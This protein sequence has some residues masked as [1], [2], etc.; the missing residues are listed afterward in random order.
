LSN[1]D[2]GTLLRAYF[3]GDGTVSRARAVTATTASPELAS[4]LAYAL[5]RFGIHARLRT[6]TKRATNSGHAGGEYTMITISGQP[7]LCAFDQHIG[8]DIE[9][10]QSRLDGQI[11]G[12]ANTNV[13]VVPINGATLRDLRR[14]VGL[15][16]SVLGERC[17]RSRSAV[18]F[19]ETGKRQPP[20]QVFCRMLDA[21]KAEAV[22][23]EQPTAWHEAWSSLDQLSHVRWTPVTAVEE[24]DY[25][26]PY[27]YDLSVPGPETFLA[28]AGG[29]F[30]HNTF[31]I[32]NVIEE[33]NR[34]TLVMSHNKTL[35]AQL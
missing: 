24:V 1:E 32:A 5:L 23:T 30:V 35:A 4:D 34:P 27:V 15:S 9:E 10:K 26:H 7:D 20:R 18:Q 19:Y 14:Q 31:T 22:A 33:I 3:D 11:G 6:V 16:A 29:M 13:D 8:F 21:L 25:D 12:A 2:L 17:G 28:G